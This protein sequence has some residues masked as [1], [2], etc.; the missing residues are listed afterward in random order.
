MREILFHG[1][2]LSD[3]Q[4]IEGSLLV[5]GERRFIIPNEELLDGEKLPTIYWAIVR[6]TCEVDPKTVGQYTGRCARCGTKI[7]EGDVVKASC[8]YE[9]PF[10]ID[11]ESS[12]EKEFVVAGTVEYH[13]GYNAFGIRGIYDDTEFHFLFNFGD[14]TIL[15]NIHDN[16][17]LVSGAYR[18]EDYHGTVHRP[19]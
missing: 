7:F 15:G 13:E 4:W 16:P 10:Q 14:I 11:E 6:K 17:E 8:T 1:K 9:Y 3:G 5:L 18:L 2:R 19:E 12:Q